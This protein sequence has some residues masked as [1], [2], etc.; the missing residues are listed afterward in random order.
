MLKTE[1]ERRAA[2]G[3]WSLREKPATDVE[4]QKQYERGLAHSDPD[5]SA[6]FF[7]NDFI[8]PFRLSSACYLACGSPDAQCH[9]HRL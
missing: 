4:L 7:D 6:R 2:E 8:A 9:F 1:H 3:L 5:P